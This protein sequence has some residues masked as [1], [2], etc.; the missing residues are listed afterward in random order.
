MPLMSPPV[1]VLQMPVSPRARGMN[2]YHSSHLREHTKLSDS[3]GK[4]P[5]TKAKVY[6]AVLIGTWP[7]AMRPSRNV[8]ASRC[9]H[10]SVILVVF[11]SICMHRAC[12]PT[13]SISL[14]CSAGHGPTTNRAPSPIRSRGGGFRASSFIQIHIP[15]HFHRVVS[16]AGIISANIHITPCH[17]TPELCTG[18]QAME[19]ACQRSNSVAQSLSRPWLGVAVPTNQPFASAK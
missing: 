2:A 11:I 18:L 7:A 3:K 16:A 12:I 17:C 8:K 13:A 19:F 6:N 5:T 1:L 15:V 14:S 9:F 4:G 10:Q